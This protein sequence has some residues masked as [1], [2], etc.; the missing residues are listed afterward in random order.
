M[1][2][3]FFKICRQNLS[4]LV[5]VTVLSF[6]GLWFSKNLVA[7]PVLAAGKVITAIVTDDDKGKA[8]A[9]GTLLAELA[10]K[11]EGLPLPPSQAGSLKLFSDA[12]KETGQVFSGITLTSTSIDRTITVKTKNAT[13]VTFIS[14]SGLTAPFHFKGGSYP[15]TSGTCKT[16]ITADCTLVLSFTPRN[17]PGG[18]SDDLMRLTTYEQKISIQ[19]KTLGITGVTGDFILKGKAPYVPMVTSRVGEVYFNA[20]VPGVISRQ[21]FVFDVVLMSK[22]SPN[23]PNTVVG[24]GEVKNVSVDDLEPPFLLESKAPCAT[25]GESALQNGCTLSV[26]YTPTGT[27]PDETDLTLR[28]FDGLENQTARVHLRGSGMLPLPTETDNNLLFPTDPV[29]NLLV[30][31]ND[32]SIESGEVKD[33]YLANRPG[34]SNANFVPISYPPKGCTAS[35][36]DPNGETVTDAELFQTAI[37]RPIVDWITAHP[38]KDIRYIVLLRGVPTRYSFTNQT[39]VLETMSLSYALSRAFDE[40]CVRY[41]YRPEKGVNLTEFPA[42]P[43]CPAPSERAIGFFRKKAFPGTLALVTVLDMGSV[44]DTKAYTDKLKNMYDRMAHKSLKISA[45]DA[46]VG[47]TT[48]YLEDARE[49]SH[50]AE[51]ISRKKALEDISTSAT[52]RYVPDG[53]WTPPVTEVEDVLGFMTW[54]MHAGRGQNYATDRQFVFSGNSN[55]YIIDTLESYNGMRN[56]GSQSRYIDWFL[57]N[58]FGGT[59]YSATP[60]GAVVSVAEPYLVGKNSPKFFTC[61][62]QGGLFADCAW[63][64]KRSKMTMAVGDPWVVK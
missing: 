24:L 10:K 41:E 36:P 21:S 46:G 8:E 52:I 53:Q 44:R 12:G 3:F 5:A 64:S 1:I 30:V 39:G 60:A 33:Y 63:Q 40:S 28:Y 15:G 6:A 20:W 16:E 17:E 48:Y 31:Y 58:S 54:G 13:P 50:S 38:T 59:N 9:I 62:D 34:F 42:S 18:A 25:E 47:G 61:W 29:S 26:I 14:L 23:T 45:T 56:N 49:D 43:N 4:A 27:N 55:W 57:S 51:A 35:C 19:F 37:K 11:L 2:L 7:T 22:D 32:Q